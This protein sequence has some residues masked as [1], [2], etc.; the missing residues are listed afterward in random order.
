MPYLL[1]DQENGTYYVS[2]WEPT[3]CNLNKW[4]GKN[5]LAKRE[6]DERKLIHEKSERFLSEN[7]CQWSKNM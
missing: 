5:K 3:F 7:G 6:L 2:L 4:G 1:D